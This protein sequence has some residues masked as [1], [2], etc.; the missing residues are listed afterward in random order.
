MSLVTTAL[1]T[2]EAD[3]YTFGV[4]LPTLIGLKLNLKA[5]LDKNLVFHCIPL[6]HALHQGLES[7]FG[8]LMDPFNENGKSIPLY[9]AM[10][11]NPAYKM[12]FLGIKKISAVLLNRFKEMLYD[13]SQ[14][15]EHESE[16]SGGDI[17][18][19]N[20]DTIVVTNGN[21][22]LFSSFHI[23]F[24]S[25]FFITFQFIHFFSIYL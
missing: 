16:K 21:G 1:K 7:R 9:I 11:T 8:E 19:D 23:L 18:N 4:Y 22:K 15:I 20:T 3:R 17:C 25:I 13:A 5:L 24:I 2:L 14:K 10:L 12:N 6:V